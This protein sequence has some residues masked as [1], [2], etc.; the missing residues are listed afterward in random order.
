MTILENIKTKDQFRSHIRNNYNLLFSCESNGQGKWQLI[1]HKTN[2][3]SSTGSINFYTNWAHVST[4][5]MIDNGGNG[6]DI[7]FDNILVNM[8]EDREI[9]LSKEIN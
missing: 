2:D 7:E 1:N 5:D 4:W 3:I 9:I 6:V 8:I